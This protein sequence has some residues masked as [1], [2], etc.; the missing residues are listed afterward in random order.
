MTTANRSIN[1][2]RGFLYACTYLGCLFV[3]LVAIGWLVLIGGN[4]MEVKNMGVVSYTG[5]PSE[6][7]NVGDVA[8]IRR[9]VCADHDVAIQ[10]FPA[11]IDSRGFLFAL[12]INMT[13]ALEGCHENTY[14]FV[15]PDLPPGEYTYTNSV[16]FQN[17]LVGRNEFTTFPP[18]RVRIMQ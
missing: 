5:Y 17:N 1:R 6:R 18:L 15:V 2:N 16:L 7:F 4:P 12:P 8:G 13:Q 11:L 9:Q 10:S 14:G 3:G